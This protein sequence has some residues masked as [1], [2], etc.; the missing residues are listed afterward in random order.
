MPVSEQNPL[1]DQLREVHT[2]ALERLS[3]V[4]LADS[5]SAAMMSTPRKA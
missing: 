3:Q 5:L 4:S 1:V 2:E